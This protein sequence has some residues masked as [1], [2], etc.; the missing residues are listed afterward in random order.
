MTLRDDRPLAEPGRPAPARGRRLSRALEVQEAVK[1]LIVRRGLTAGDPMPTETE[2]MRE[3]DIGRNSV[4]EAL[5][6]LQAV[7]IVDIRHGFGM[8]VGQMS[9]NGLVDE[10]AFHSRITPQDEQ[11]HLAHLIEIRE[12]LENGLAARLIDRHGG[13]DLADLLSPAREAL[14]QMEAEALVGAVSPETDRL[15]H[16]AL[17]RPLGNPLVGRLLGAFWQVFH[18]LRDELGTPDETP[19]YV[20]RKHRDIYAAVIAEDRDAVEAAMVAHFAGIRTRL[21]RLRDD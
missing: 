1:E 19:E 6:A 3:L 13:A 10:L 7:G 9:L 21:A 8:F 5:K 14:E 12:L 16:D 4:R 11:S 15:F 17:H 2:L 20:A 18:Q